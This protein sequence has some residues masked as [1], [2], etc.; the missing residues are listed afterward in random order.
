ME[1]EQKKEELA[2]IEEQNELQPVQEIDSLTSFSYDKNKSIDEN[3][4]D[5]IELKASEKAL[6]DTKFVS[7]VADIKKEQIKESAQINKDIH[8]AKKEAE[9]VEAL[10]EIDR[11]F[12][13][14][15]KVPLQFG[16]IQEPTTRNFSIFMLFLILPFFTVLTVFII[17]PINIIKR[18]LQAINHLFIEID[19]FGKIGRSIAFTLLILAVIGILGIS[20]YSTLC[21]FG[22]I[23][24]I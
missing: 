1:E 24:S 11:A 15:W 16:G 17:M 9:K 10:T 4:S 12:Y 2:P 3:A 13:E 8:V 6:E 19:K 5:L 14:K 22:I 18:L 20:I 21:G 7:N 23:P